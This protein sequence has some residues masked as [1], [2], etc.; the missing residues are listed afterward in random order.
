MICLFGGTFDPVHLGHLHAAERVRET[1]A[2]PEVRLLLSAHPSHK[3]STG[4]SLEDRW[5]MLSA[6]CAAHPGLVADNR[7]ARRNKPSYTVDTLLEFRA[8]HPGEA[9]TWVMGSDAYALLPSW[10]RWEAVLEL[11]NLVVL[12][13]PGPFPALDAVMTELTARHRVDNLSGC[14]EGGILLVED[15]M[16]E[17]SAADVRERVAAGAPV[18]HL[19]PAVVANYIS[20]HHLYGG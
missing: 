7:E 14:H 4:A 16:E 1:L 15:A 10:Y 20:S 2:V 13:R 11:A 9:L 12:A 19:L 8:E 17:V 3:A 18:S 6:A 5:A